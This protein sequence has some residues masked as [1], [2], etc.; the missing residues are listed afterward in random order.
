MT[1]ASQI[2]TGVG[3]LIFVSTLLQTSGLFSAEQTTTYVTI[4]P[5]NSQIFYPS[6]SAPGTTVSL[7]ESRISA[8]T[9]GRILALHVRV[10]DRIAKGGLLAEL[11]CRSNRA[12]LQQN[13]AALQ[14]A[15]A[16]ET[17]AQRQFKRS[18]SLR[19]SRSMSE[20]LYN[21]READVATTKADRLAQQARLAEAR[22]NVERCNLYA[23][24]DALVLERLANQG[25]WVTA[26]QG[27]V[28][29][30]D[31]QQLEVSGQIPLTHINSLAQAT[32]II[33]EDNL[34]NYPLQLRA[35]LPVI[36]KRSR[37][38]EARLL[39]TGQKA[40]PGSSGRIT[41]SSPI[42]HLPADIP[43]RRG[44]QIGV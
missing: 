40:L 35:Q 13:E 37:N 4:A 33:F 28:R 26:G 3:W 8:E 24:F 10:G 14:A 23:P 34:G 20:E 39:F 21:Q 9:A 11:D 27:I 41:W 5:L 31:S 17:L 6:L 22:L 2:K 25:E 36:A 15:E 42:P 30:L 12:L 18:Q 32:D 29:L 43:V 19:K 38:Q 16:R 1:T 7:N 44:N